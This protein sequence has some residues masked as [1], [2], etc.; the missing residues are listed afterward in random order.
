[1][2]ET[3]VKPFNLADAIREVRAIEGKMKVMVQAFEDKLKPYKEFAEGRRAEILAHLLSTG[4]K[5]ANTEF[6]GAYWKEK[7]TYRVEDRDEFRR[8]VIGTEAWELLVWGAAGVA[9]EEFTNK[10]GEPPPGTVR[11]A[12]V[13][14]YVT[15]PVKP[16]LV[17]K[18]PSEGAPMEDLQGDPSEQEPETAA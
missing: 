10:H 3:Q 13:L 11:N 12:V 17:K 1:M 18:T 9:A 7:V 8:H 2:T 6:G 16:R 15:A 14:P 4:Q 5:S